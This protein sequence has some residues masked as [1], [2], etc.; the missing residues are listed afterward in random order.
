MCLSPIVENRA[1]REPATDS[2]ASETNREIGLP[3]ESRVFKRRRHNVGEP[4]IHTTLE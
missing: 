1:E 3:L 2:R 4:Y